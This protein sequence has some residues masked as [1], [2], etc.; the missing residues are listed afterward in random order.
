MEPI[1]EERQDAGLDEH[2]IHFLEMAFRTDK[3]GRPPHPDGCGKKTGDCG[4]SVEMFLTVKDECIDAVS[5]HLDGCMNTNACAN[6]VA[7]LAEGK[8]L[9]E[10][11]EISV[12]QVVDCLQSLPEDHIHCAELAVGTFYLALA[13]C[14]KIGRAPWKKAYR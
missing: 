13:D 14:R 8:T 5:F 9:D 11:W 4:D 12:D 3:Q 6:T 2:T 10:A 1:E 7:L